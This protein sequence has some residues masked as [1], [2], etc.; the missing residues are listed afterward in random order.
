M[1]MYLVFGEIRFINI[2]AKDYPRTQVVKESDPFRQ[3]NMGDT[4]SL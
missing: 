1:Y 4:Y 3:R 2:F